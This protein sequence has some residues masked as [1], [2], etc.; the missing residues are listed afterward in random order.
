M[1]TTTTTR[2]ETFRARLRARKEQQEGTS[3]MARMLRA[4]G[5]PASDASRWM[6][7]LLHEHEA[8]RWLKAGFRDPTEVGGILAAELSVMGVCLDEHHPTFLGAESMGLLGPRPTEPEPCKRLDPCGLCG[9]CI[10]NHV[11]ESVMVVLTVLNLPCEFAEAA[12]WRLDLVAEWASR[13]FT[14]PGVAAR[15]RRLGLTADRAYYAIQTVGLS[16]EDLSRR[17][18]RD[19]LPK[20]H[21]LESVWVEP[22]P[23][24]C[25]VCFDYLGSDACEAENG[26]SYCSRECAD[27]VTP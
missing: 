5:L 8:K 17:D 16:L 27:W 1:N 24:Q 15:L 21:P 3:S 11:T 9:P 10:R 26:N 20:W 7:L 13:G 2:S 6:H 25:P 14:D 19:A 22:E 23:P 4:S 12:P 18:A